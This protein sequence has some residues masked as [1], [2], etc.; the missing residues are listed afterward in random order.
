VCILPLGPISAT[1]NEC[2]NFLG[3]VGQRNLKQ[4]I[5]LLSRHPRTARHYESAKKRRQFITLALPVR[6]SA[7]CGPARVASEYQKR[8][9]P[10]NRAR[11]V[12]AKTSPFEL[13]SAATGRVVDEQQPFGRPQR[14]C[15]DAKRNEY[16]ER[17]CRAAAEVLTARGRHASPQDS[18]RRVER[19]SVASPS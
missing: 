13:R 17:A 1:R 11:L 19:S 15:H 10:P 4:K 3:G 5:V 9:A 16:D 6:V 12:I 7:D 14:R 2:Q 18:Y 8:Y